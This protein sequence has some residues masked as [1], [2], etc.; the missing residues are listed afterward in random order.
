MIPTLCGTYAL[1]GRLRSLQ[2]E[3]IVSS[4]N[5]LCVVVVEPS[6]LSHQR[7]NFDIQRGINNS[8]SIFTVGRRNTHNI[9]HSK[10]IRYVI[11]LKSKMVGSHVEESIHR[12]FGRPL[13]S[14]KLTVALQHLSSPTSSSRTVCI[15]SVGRDTNNIVSNRVGR[16]PLSGFA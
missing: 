3:I 15:S 7:S 8:K 16:F 12:K 5:H 13:V 14:Q 4:K 10:N 9:T 6:L 11:P 1:Y 2:L